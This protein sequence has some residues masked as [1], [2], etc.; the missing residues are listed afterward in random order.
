MIPRDD[1][2]APLVAEP[3]PEVLF[4][5]K[6]H[7]RRTEKFAGWLRNLDVDGHAEVAD[8]LA[9]LLT[10]AQRGQAAQ[11][12]CETLEARVRWL[13]THAE[14]SDARHDHHEMRLDRAGIPRVDVTADEDFMAGVEPCSI[15][16]ERHGRWP[17]AECPVCEP[18]I[19]MMVHMGK[20]VERER[21]VIGQPVT[22][23]YR[24]AARV[25]N[26]RKEA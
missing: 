22:I 19:R 10:E 1:G 26:V 5:A 24:D 17:G 3:E 2:P 16:C 18:P 6:P 23:S 20:K 9:Y 14:G 8:M 13:E 11:Q 21:L 4:P 15:V 25:L 7:T 12:R